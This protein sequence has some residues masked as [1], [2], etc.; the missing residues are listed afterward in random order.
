MT[1]SEPRKRRGFWR[2]LRPATVLLLV[3]ILIGGFTVWVLWGGLYDYWVARQASE[4]LITQNWRAAADTM[5]RVQPTYQRKFAYYEVKPGQTMSEIA[6][7]FGVSTDRLRELNAG[8]TFVG[9]VTIKVPPVERP[10]SEVEP[11]DTLALADIVQE[12]DIIRLIHDYDRNQ[13]IRTTIPELRQVLAS[14]DAI[15]RVGSKTYRIVRPVQLDGDIRLDVTADTV[16]NLELVSTDN[17]IAPLLMD[18]G[19]VLFK[20]VHVTSVDPVTGEPDPSS[21]NGRAYIRMKNGRMDAINSTFSWLGNGLAIHLTKKAAAMDVEAEGGTYGFSYRISSD[22]LGAE[23]TTGWVEGSTFDRL[24]FGAYSYGASGMMWKDNLF[25]QNEVYGLDPH[26]DSNNAMVVGNRFLYNGKH[27]F[28]VS[29]RCNYNVI[30]NNTSVG[31][32]LHGYMLHQD[33]AYNVIENNVA[34]DNSGDNFAIYESNWNT[35]RGNKSYSPGK[36]HVRISSASHNSYIVDNYFAG[37]KKGVYIYENSSAT[38]IA[39][40]EFND[41][42]RPLQTR[43]ADNTFYA[44]NTSKDFKY[45]I[46]AG[47]KVIF[48]PNRIRKAVDEVPSRAEIVSGD[49]AQ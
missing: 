48:G 35:I 49:L 9:G 32:K 5:E 38:Y 7:F 14:Y 11:T 22:K 10:M 25:T 13:P 41:L 43:N 23:I 17:V 36:S 6:S 26:D 39:R 8:K 19:S 40:N 30:Q 18:G 15:E 24:H 46:Q 44:R 42:S 45:D 47:D 37:A 33:S 2:H 20:D 29:K 27:G 12:G 1:L 3:P 16:E 28:I 34:Y 31:N 4:R 21:R